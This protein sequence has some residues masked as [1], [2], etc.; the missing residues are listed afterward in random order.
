MAFNP[1]NPEWPKQAADL[2]DRVVQIVRRNLTNRAV[3]A[4]NGIVFG[5]LAVFA[6]LVALVLGVVVAM[7]SVQSYLTWDMG[8]V[9]AWIVGMLAG[10]GVLVV[11]VGL[12]R[13]KKLAMLGGALLLGFTGARWA[14]FA[15]DAR[16]DHNT[17]VWISD[18]IVGGLFVLLGAFLMAKRHSPTES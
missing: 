6:G 18:V 1:L 7:R 17:S 4:T 8:T 2:V 16:I 12:I 10:A 13:S 9:A 3:K 14:I 5:L 15:G 11:I